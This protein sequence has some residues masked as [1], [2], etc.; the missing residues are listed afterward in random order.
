MGSLGHSFT[1]WVVT[2]PFTG[3]GRVITRGA[4]AKGALAVSVEWFKRDY[5]VAAITYPPGRMSNGTIPLL[6]R[7]PARVYLGPMTHSKA[8][9][10]PGR[11]P[12]V[13]YI[14]PGFKCRELQVTQPFT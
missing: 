8:P 9:R 10:G 13:S 1:T 14:I 7:D 2:I 6:F 3:R 11:S 5:L 12:T 4:D